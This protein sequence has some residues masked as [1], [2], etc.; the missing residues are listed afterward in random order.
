LG[1]KPSRTTRRGAFSSKYAIP[2]S[3]DVCRQQVEISG[4]CTAAVANRAICTLRRSRIETSVPD[5]RS[6]ANRNMIDVRGILASRLIVPLRLQSS[7]RFE[8][9]HRLLASSAVTRLP[10]FYD[11][12][13]PQ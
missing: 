5:N 7:L 10:M 1:V 9:D 6:S 13:R 12:N 3:S 4:E 2:A 8:A 11:S